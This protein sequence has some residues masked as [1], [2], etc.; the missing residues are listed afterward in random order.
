[1]GFQSYAFRWFFGYSIP[2]GGPVVPLCECP[3]WT[4]DSTLVNV[5]TNEQT[6]SNQ[7]S[8]DGTLSNQFNRDVTLLNEFGNIQTLTNQWG[9]RN[10]N[11]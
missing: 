1:M 9:K 7:F 4:Q 6:I 3:E 8:K 2:S 5:F 11:G 10:C